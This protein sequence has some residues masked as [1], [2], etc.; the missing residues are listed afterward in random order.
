V[1]E[2]PERKLTENIRV[3]IIFRPSVAH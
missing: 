3:I 1:K 2:Q